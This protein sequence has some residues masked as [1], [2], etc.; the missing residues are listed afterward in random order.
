MQFGYGAPNDFLQEAYL[1][2]LAQ[3]GDE[4]KELRNQLFNMFRNPNYQTT[5]PLAW[6]YFYGDA[7]TI[8]PPIPPRNY[9]AM[10]Q[11]QYRMLASWK[12]GNFTSDVERLKDLPHRFEQVKLQD[13]PEMLTKAALW[14]CLGEAFH[15]GCEMTWPMRHYTMYRGAFRI[16][17][18]DANDPQTDYGPILTPKVATSEVGPLYFNSPGDITRWMAVP[19]QTDTASCRSGYTPDYD[20]YLPTFW[21]ARVPNQ[22]LIEE[23]YHIIV[24]PGQYSRDERIAAFNRRLDWLRF[25]KGNQWPQVNQMVKDFWRLGVVER[26]Q[27]LSDDPDFPDFFYVE[28]RPEFPQADPKLE[29]A[30]FSAEAR[31]DRHLRAAQR[32]DLPRG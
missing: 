1:E 7:V 9:L 30:E 22:V 16:R 20:P 6:P 13:Q 15:P 3:S 2:K 19:W 29:K 32:M 21:A 28:S 4:F 8:T 5:E 26:R 11:T 27:G 18:R 12:D 14:F 10:T 17:V 31:F 24:N 25:L 23:D